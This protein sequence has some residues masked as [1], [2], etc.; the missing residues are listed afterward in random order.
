MIPSQNLKTDTIKS[1][2][3]LDYIRMIPS[4]NCGGL[5]PVLIVVLDYIRMIPSQNFSFKLITTLY[6]FR[7]H[8]NDTKPKRTPLVSM[9]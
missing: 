8:K 7:L 2:I 9:L 3:V 4:Q 1:F 6:S 5:N